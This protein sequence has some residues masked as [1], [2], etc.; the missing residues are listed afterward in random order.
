MSIKTIGI[1]G[2]MVTTHFQEILRNIMNDNKIINIYIN[3]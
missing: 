3:K 2:G 1:L